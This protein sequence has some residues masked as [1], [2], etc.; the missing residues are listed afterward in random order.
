MNTAKIPEWTF[1]DRVRKVRLERTDL[2]Q[3][4]FAKEIGVNG[5]TLS[6]WES[7]RNRAPRGQDLIGIAKR[8]SART[9][10]SVEWL[11]GL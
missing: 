11:L 9:G 1:G 2:T 8:I 10:V 4:G 3:G 6:A 7:G 5:P